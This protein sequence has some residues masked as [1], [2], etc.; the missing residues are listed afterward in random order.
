LRAATEKRDPPHVVWGET[1]APPN[2]DTWRRPGYHARTPRPWVLATVVPVAPL[3]TAMKARTGAGDSRRSRGKGNPMNARWLIATIVAAGTLAG[4]AAVAPEDRAGRP[5]HV[6]NGKH[7]TVN[8]K[9]GGDCDVFV[10]VDCSTKP[11]IKVDNEFVAAEN[12]AAPIIT[13]YLVKSASDHQPD[14]RYKFAP[15]DKGIDFGGGAASTE[16]T[17][18]KTKPQNDQQF[19]CKDNQTNA[20]GTTDV[21][22]YTINIVDANSNAYELDPW[23]IN[24]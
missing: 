18:C 22:K 19:T 21:W 8:C 1:T 17:N 16:F 13:W 7:S 15:Y 11:C 5:L 4:C 23:V 24:N 10:W 12:R 14:T 9:R 2:D 6:Q 3:P 20:A